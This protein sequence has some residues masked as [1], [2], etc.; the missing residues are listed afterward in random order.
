M[1]SNSISEDALAR[2]P[3]CPSD[4]GCGTRF[5]CH[6]PAPAARRSNSGL[7]RHG[8]TPGR[9]RTSAPRAEPLVPGQQ[10][11]AVARRRRCRGV[12]PHIGAPFILRHRH[13]GDE[14]ALLEGLRRPKSYSWLASRAPSG[15]PWRGPPATPARRRRSWRSD[16]RAQPQPGTRRRSRPHVR[17]AP[18]VVPETWCCV[19]PRVHRDGHRECHAGWN[20]TSSIRWPETIMG[21]QCPGCSCPLAPPTDAPPVSPLGNR[22]PPTPRHF[23]TPR[24]ARP[25]CSTGSVAGDVPCRDQAG[26]VQHFVGGPLRR[27]DRA[28]GSRRCSLSGCGRRVLRSLPESPC[29]GMADHRP[30]VGADGVPA[31]VVAHS[32]LSEGARARRGR[33]VLAGVLL[34]WLLLGA[35]HPR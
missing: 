23:A 24:C 29:P 11:T 13:A 14:S 18:P 20:S 3:A 8:P 31:P 21:V 33:G 26:L 19:Q 17:R 1:P 4:A 6:R 7:L 12:G 16:N 28:G 25:S 22:S 35:E 27:A 32:R 15:Q 10:E 30:G 9:H 2:F 34:P 5:D